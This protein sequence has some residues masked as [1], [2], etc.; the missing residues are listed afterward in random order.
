MPDLDAFLDDCGVSA[1]TYGATP[2]NKL[3]RA[4]L[5]DR[6]GT[7]ASVAS[8]A[9]QRATFVGEVLRQA[10]EGVY[11]APTGGEPPTGPPPSGEV[12][13]WIDQAVAILIRTP[14]ERHPTGIPAQLLDPAALAIIIQH[15]SSGN[16]RAINRSYNPGGAGH[17]SGLMQ[18]IPTT[19]RAH[20]M[21]GHG[22]IW[23]P[24]DNIMAGARYA[25]GR[26]GSVSNVP[27]VK[28]RRAGKAY[29][30]GY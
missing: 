14:T 1:G 17:P 23:N 16:P 30:K 18:T 25:V 21:P 2:E 8:E 12:K 9:Q 20:A 3:Y 19:F 5:R 4:T 24:V 10:Q 7:T 27:G 26:Y 22:D 6:S 15:E 13:A 11:Q 29:G 28:N